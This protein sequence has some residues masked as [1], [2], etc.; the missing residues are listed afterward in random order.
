MTLIALMR[1]SWL[2]SVCVFK[3]EWLNEITHARTHTQTL[4]LHARLPQ[5]NQVIRKEAA[6]QLP[7]SSGRRTERQMDG[8]KRS[9]GENGT[10]RYTYLSIILKKVYILYT[11]YQVRSKSK[12]TAVLLA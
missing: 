2:E 11:R 10:P 7:F 1:I 9:L 3:L 5:I 12:A 8:E 6:H 4:K